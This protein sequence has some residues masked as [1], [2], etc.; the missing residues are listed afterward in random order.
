MN[1]WQFIYNKLKTNKKLFLIIVVDNNGSSAGKQGFKMAVCNDGTLHGSIGGGISEHNLVSDARKLLKTNESHTSFIQRIHRLGAG[2]KK[3]G[4]ICSGENSFVLIPISIEKINIIINLLNCLKANKEGVL[5]VSRNK[6]IFDYHKTIHKQFLYENKTRQTYKELIGYKN[7]AYI[8]G[9]GHVG[10]SMSRILKQIDFKVFLYDN[11][12]GLNTFEQNISADKKQIINYRNIENYIKEGENIYIFIMTFSHKS[13]E[14][15][16]SKLL[17]KKVKYI[18]MLGSR[19]KIETI[20]N[21]LKKEKFSDKELNKLY[22]PIG[23]KIKSRTAAEI[24]ISIAA[25]IIKVKNS[26]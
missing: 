8:I 14:L 26:L 9:A 3:S 19:K 11:R 16:A 25:E 20:K 21:N 1:I 2:D 7:I 15:V 18:G 17:R 10:L 13:D 5:T 4:M 12:N 22:A 24:A 23:I 6:F